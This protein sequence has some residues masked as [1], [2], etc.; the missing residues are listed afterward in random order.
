MPNDAALDAGST[1]IALTQL[2]APDSAVMVRIGA[3]AIALFDVDGALQ[4]IDDACMRCGASLMAGARHGAH[5]TCRCGWVYDLITGSV[6]GL[7]ALR[8]DKFAVTRVGDT[9]QVGSTDR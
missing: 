2:V 3:M 4:A 8:Q 7:P 6:L 5:V 1:T 9:I